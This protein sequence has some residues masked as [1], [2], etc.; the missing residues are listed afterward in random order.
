MEDITRQM[1][2]GTLTGVAQQVL[3][4][5]T[6]RLETWGVQRIDICERQSPLP[7]VVSRQRNRLR[8]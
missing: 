3:R 1:D 5:D 6:A 8:W 4:S 2:E 7:W